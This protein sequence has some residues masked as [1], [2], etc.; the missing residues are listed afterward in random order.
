MPAPLPSPV[1]HPPTHLLAPTR[2]L[3]LSD[4]LAPQ[5]VK[6]KLSEEQKANLR[7]CFK[8]M[9]ADG[10]GAIDAE[11]L[12]AAFRLLGLRVSRREV[13]AMLAEVDRDGSGGCARQQRAVGKGRDCG[14]MLQPA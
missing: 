8:M 14:C 2:L 13:E 10:S 3:L 11:E 7:M 12:D 6:P 1:A 5:T 4:D 9:D